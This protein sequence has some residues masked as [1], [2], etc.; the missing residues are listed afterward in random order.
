MSYNKYYNYN[1]KFDILNQTH[2]EIYNEYNGNLSDVFNVDEKDLK[3]IKII[4]QLVKPFNELEVLLV[5]TDEKKA[6][7]FFQE[8]LTSL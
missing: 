2:L 3:I 1:K 6:L 5:N 4:D 7:L 8:V